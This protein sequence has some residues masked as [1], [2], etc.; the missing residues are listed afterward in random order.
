MPLAGLSSHAGHPLLCCLQGVRVEHVRLKPAKA[1]ASPAL[2]HMCLSLQPDSHTVVSVRFQRVFMAVW[3][4]PADA[5]RG[6]DVPGGLLVRH[7]QVH[8]L[9]CI[10]SP[11]LFL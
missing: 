4:Q 2:L 1:H 3:E 5:H 10:T 6:V 8:V 7:S 11:F 9:P